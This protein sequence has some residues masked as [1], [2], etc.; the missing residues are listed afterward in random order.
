MYI[1][2]K[3]YPSA[4]SIM[5]CAIV[6]LAAV[7][8]QGNAMAAQAKQKTFATP[9]EAI[10][11][12]A[13]SIRDNN[14]SEI[15]AILGPGSETLISS[16]DKVSDRKGREK[17]IKRY[18]ENN[19]MEKSGDKKVILHVGSNDWPFPIPVVM[20]GSRWCFDTKE[21]REELLNRRIGENELTTIQTCLAIVDAERE[22]ATLDRNGNGLIE[23]AQKLNSTRVKMDGLYWEVKPGEKPSP[24]GPLIAKARAGGYTKGEKPTPY[25]GYFFLILTGQGKYAHGGAYSY[26]VKGNMIGGFALLAY[27]ASYEVSGVKTFIV[28]HE[29][30]VYEKDL[31]PK[32]SEK[33]K[34]MKEFNPDKTWDK[35]E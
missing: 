18:D 28:N 26:L 11:S 22:Y 19:H 27:P 31:G 24:L 35:A 34:A 10:Q 6:L 3:R 4:R 12:L 13:R 23:Y 15:F 25:Y 9:D 17:F 29:G 14:V 16:G 1:L 2:Q 7:T 30:V 20:T 21:G 33:A 32:T 5:S 8:L